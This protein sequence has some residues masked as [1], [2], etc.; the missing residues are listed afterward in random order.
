M[1]YTVLLWLSYLSRR[2]FSV[3]YCSPSTRSSKSIHTL[4]I[5]SSFF[6]RVCRKE[7]KFFLLFLVMTDRSHKRFFVGDISPIF[8]QLK[9]ESKGRKFDILPN[10]LA[11]TSIPDKTSQKIDALHDIR[12]MGLCVCVFITTYNC[13]CFSTFL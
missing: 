8:C 5:H 12:G 6:T 10:N 3:H 13:T 7:V 4:Q 2:G 1:G 11:C 9:R